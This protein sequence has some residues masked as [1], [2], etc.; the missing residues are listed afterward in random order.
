MS[1]RSILLLMTASACTSPPSMPDATTD[2]GLDAGPV[3]CDADPLLPGCVPTER[4]SFAGLSAPVEI[5]RDVDG[6]PHV[7]GANTRDV[8]YG[9]GYAQA[10]DRLFEMDLSRRR[11]LGRRAEVLGMAFVDGD[12]LTRVVD[13]P[14]WG[15]T[16]EAALFRD[17][18]ELWA[19]LQAWVE[20]VNARIDEV[21]SGS[22]PMPAEF[23]TLRFEPERWTPADALAFG[24]LVLFGNANQIEYTI[25]AQILHQYFPDVETNLG[26]LLPF[27]D[28][29]VLPPEERPAAGAMPFASHAASPLALPAD[30]DERIAR[31]QRTMSAFRPGASNNW[32]VDGP[33]TDS[34]RPLIAGDPHQPLQ[35]PSLFWMHHLAAADGSLDVVGWSFVG[36]PTVALGHNRHVAWTATTTYPDMMDVWDVSVRAGMVSVGGV[37]VA[38]RPRMERIEVA[39]GA[40]VDL[41]VQEVPGY[42]VLLPDGLAPLPIGR[43]GRELLFRWTGFGVTHELEGFMAV[44]RARSRAEFEAAV[45]RIEL[46]AF[47]FVSADQEGISYRAPPRVPDRGTPTD[48][49]APYLVLDGD[50]PSTY[51]DGTF[52]GSALL[53]RSHGGARGWLGSA[54]N[55]PYGFVSDGRIEGDPFYYGVFFDPGVRSARIEGEL[56]RLVTRGSVSLADMEALQDDTYTLYADDFVPLLDDAWASRGTD[57][58]LATFR[59]RA[60]LDALVSRL[61]AWDR[62]MERTSSEAVVFHAFMFFLAERVLRDDLSVLFQPILEAESAYVLK[63]LSLVMRGAAPHPEAALGADTREVALAEALDRTAR[64]LTERFPSGSY[65]WADLHGTLFTSLYGDRLAAPWVPTDGSCGTLNRADT[66]FFASTDTPHERLDASDGSIYRMVASFGADGTPQAFFT[67]GQGV[68]GEPTSPHWDDLRDDWIETRHRP[69]RYLRA[70]VE[71]GPVERIMLTP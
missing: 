41:V 18:P 22:A 65:V 17:D 35:S 3:D 50:D 28:S 44:D 26:L 71:A 31:W 66:V 58:L 15:R 27:R 67:M 1:M 11:A 8:M 52:L 61:H 59:D 6:V 57:P 69:L 37:E 49:R 32:A 48:A 36:G 21:L 34:G 4:P 54:N 9:D 2:A 51:W 46:A 24:K 19:L 12:R 40:P 25:L 16:N 13:I 53:P 5:V 23:T 47:N 7:Y 55:D 63:W 62:R 64:W 56:D 10:L 60:D 30:A 42:G 43:P 45:D 38:V 29:Y 70:D 39:G 33:H 20:G 68:S 14:R